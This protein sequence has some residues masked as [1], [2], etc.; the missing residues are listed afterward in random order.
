[1]KHVIYNELSASRN[2]NNMALLG[3]LF[4]NKP[5]QAAKVNIMIGT[6]SYMYIYIFDRYM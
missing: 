1:M 5:E 3:M 4:Q 6:C 2:P